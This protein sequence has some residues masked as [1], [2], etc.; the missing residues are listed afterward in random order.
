MAINDYEYYSTTKS[1]VYYKNENNEYVTQT[2]L[3]ALLKNYVYLT[4]IKQYFSAK[5]LLSELLNRYVMKTTKLREDIH[6]ITVNTYNVETSKFNTFTFL[7]NDRSLYKRFRIYKNSDMNDYYTKSELSPKKFI[8]KM[9]Q[10]PNC[11]VKINFYQFE[12]D[13]LKTIKSGIENIN[14]KF[15]FYK[16]CIGTPIGCETYNKRMWIALL[17][18]DFDSYSISGSTSYYNESL[19]LKYS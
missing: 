12:W 19:D 5:D 10:D 8:N 3:E 14:S 13:D 4:Q 17:T 18:P 1:S 16:S 2:K 6:A 11:V 7:V 9:I 15:G